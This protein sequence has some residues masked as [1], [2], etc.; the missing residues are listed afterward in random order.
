LKRAPGLATR[1]PGPAIAGIGFGVGIRFDEIPEPIV[2]A[3]AERGLALVEVPLPTPFIA[4]TQAVARRV[5]EQEV[6]SLQKA[7]TYQ[8]RVTR[9]AVRGGLTGLVGVL[10]RKLHCEPVVLDEYGAVMASS[11][12]DEQLLKLVRTEW[13]HAPQGAG[14]NGRH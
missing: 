13:Q 1:D 7:L 5:S 8:R 4:I 12:R 6:E 9:A 14:R 3:C 11:T 10:S 2:D